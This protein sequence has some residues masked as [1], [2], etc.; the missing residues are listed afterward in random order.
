LVEIDDAQHQVPSSG[1]GIDE[2]LKEREVGP[3]S[4]ARDTYEEYAEDARHHA[5]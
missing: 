5:G 3:G 4:T 1:G 2:Y